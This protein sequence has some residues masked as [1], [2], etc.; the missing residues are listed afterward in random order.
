MQ[1]FHPANKVADVD[2]VPSKA[3]TIVL[4]HLHT[5][6]LL[7]I[8]LQQ[9]GHRFI[10]LNRWALPPAAGYPEDVAFQVLYG[11]PHAIDRFVTTVTER[12]AS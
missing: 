5:T 2:H 9:Q 11:I 8:G 3:Q 4:V 12:V 7:M 10:T 1:L 6:L